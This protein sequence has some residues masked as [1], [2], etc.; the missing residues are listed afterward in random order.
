MGWMLER[1]HGTEVI[2]RLVLPSNTYPKD[3]FGSILLRDLFGDVRASWIEDDLSF[4][5]FEVP[6]GKY[7]L[8]VNLVGW[9]FLPVLVEVNEK[10]TVT[11]T[12]RDREGPLQTNEVNLS[13]VGTLS[14]FE[15]SRTLFSIQA[16]RRNPMLAMLVVLVLAAVI[17]PKV[18]DAI[19][20]EGYRAAQEEWARTG[21]LG[22]I[23]QGVSGK[24]SDPRVEGSGPSSSTST[25]R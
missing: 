11:F 9:M 3:A 12:L 7:V 17:L 25:I 19:D 6:R 14:Y 22:Q 5:F 8:E 18:M 15:T 23:M 13:P 16:I 1:V 21:S 24:G 10:E 2:G 20:P 4:R